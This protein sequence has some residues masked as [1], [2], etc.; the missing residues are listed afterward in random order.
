MSENTAA[1]TS[2]IQAMK[3]YA[4]HQGVKLAYG[5]ATELGGERIIPVALW[6]GDAGGGTSTGADGNE[7][8]G[9]GYGGIAIPLGVYA[10]SGA[11]T[12]FRPNIIALLG[13]ATPLTFVGG[14]ALARIIRA[15][16]RKRR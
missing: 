14:W 13:A 3:E 5:E 2:K 16:K 6:A 12:T 9:A 4:E 10:S 11:G 7:G 8:D 15:L 1:D